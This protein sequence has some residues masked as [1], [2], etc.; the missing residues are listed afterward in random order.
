MEGQVYS[1]TIPEELKLKRDELVVELKQI[2][3]DPEV[4]VRAEEFHKEI[5][6]LSLERLLRPFDI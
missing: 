5:S 3:T 4:L 6:S 1:I 2:A